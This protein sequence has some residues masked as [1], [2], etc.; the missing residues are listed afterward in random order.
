MP[1]TPAGKDTML[2]ALD[3]TQAAGIDFL[4]LHSAFPGDTGTNELTGGAPAYARK[5]AA[6]GAASGG[7]KAL[8]GTAVFDVPAGATVAWVSGWDAVTAGNIRAYSPVGGGALKPFVVPDIANDI[9]EAPAHGFSNG[10]QVVVWGSAL[11]G[12]LAVGTIY[13]V[14]AATTDDLQLSATSGGAAINITSVGSGSLQRI[15]PET[16]GAQGQYTV[17]AFTL[18]VEN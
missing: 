5:A 14:V 15:I 2:E 17:N 4:G 12:G 9:L 11:P 16:F 3:E 8:T 18:S 6:W 1:F 7:S 10:Q 13:F